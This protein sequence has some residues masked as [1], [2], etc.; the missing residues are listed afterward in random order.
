MR[1]VRV[2]IMHAIAGSGKTTLAK[3]MAGVLRDC[4]IVSKDDLRTVDGVYCFDQSNEAELNKR[5]FDLGEGYIMNK[6]YKHLILDN[7]HLNFEFMKKTRL[8]IEKYKVEYVI[9]SI[10][11]NENI[12]V[13]QKLN[14]HEVPINVLEGQVIQFNKF[15]RYQYPIIPVSMWTEI[16]EITKMLEPVW[17]ICSEFFYFGCYI[18]ED[19]IK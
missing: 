15:N 12:E 1:S 18:G 9:I 3:S 16:H 17:K 8:L 13:H 10:H 4:H 14:V 19:D 5:Y 6:R 2:I 11:P 7:T